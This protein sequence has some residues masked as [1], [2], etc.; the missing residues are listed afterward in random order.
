MSQA[1]FRSLDKA[2]LCEL[3]ARTVLG[4]AALQA[5]RILRRHGTWVSVPAATIHRDTWMPGDECSGA[6]LFCHMS[7]GGGFTASGDGS[8]SRMHF[9]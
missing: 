1:V 2:R 8:E 4:R 3:K 5:C 9:G 7:L 6:V